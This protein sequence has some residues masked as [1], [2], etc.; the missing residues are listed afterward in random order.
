MPNVRFEI[1][2]SNMTTPTREATWSFKKNTVLVFDLIEK[3][4][5][6]LLVRPQKMFSLKNE[7]KKKKKKK[8]K[9]PK[10]FAKIVV[11]EITQNKRQ[12]NM[13]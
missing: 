4:G 10:K 7:E 2:F 6:L 12:V 9:K 13:F 5:I 8:K 3:D 11:D 1:F